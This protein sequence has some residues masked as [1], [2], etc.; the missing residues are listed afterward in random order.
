M[1]QSTLV[2][3]SLAIFLFHYLCKPWVADFVLQH[4]SG[5][6]PICSSNK[7]GYTMMK[8]YLLIKQYN[9]AIFQ[10]IPQ[11]F[12]QQSTVSYQK[13]I[14]SF[15]TSFN[16]FNEILFLKF[17][18]FKVYFKTAFK[19]SCQIWVNQPKCKYFFSFTIK[20]LSQISLRNE[21]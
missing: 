3:L 11:F 16:I 20:R 21:S 9:F 4:H 5:A 18:Q 13:K 6:F 8:M 7:D 2:Y 17:T 19:D 14:A 10:K 15:R 1:L 12:S